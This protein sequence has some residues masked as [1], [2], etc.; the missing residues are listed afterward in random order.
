MSYEDRYI[1]GVPNPKAGKRGYGRRHHCDSI[2]CPVC[3]KYVVRKIRKRILSDLPSPNFIV[4][5]LARRTHILNHCREKGISYHWLLETSFEELKAKDQIIIFIEG[6][7][8]G[9]EK[10]DSSDQYNAL[11]DRFCGLGYLDGR[12]KHGSSFKFNGHEKVQNKDDMV[13][14]PKQEGKEMPKDITYFL[15]PESLFPELE[16]LGSKVSF[17]KGDD[18]PDAPIENVSVDFSDEALKKFWAIK[19]PKKITPFFGRD[20]P[21]ARVSVI[22]RVRK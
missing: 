15:V 10:I 17:G 21:W 4:M 13:S 11:L 22:K 14:T 3:G 12:M 20:D 19:D 9:F 5:S 18:D 1:L 7:L 2:D 16:K 8:K 6:S